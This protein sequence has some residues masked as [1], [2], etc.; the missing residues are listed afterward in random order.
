MN[1][2]VFRRSF[3]VSKAKRCAG[4]ANRVGADG[5]CRASRAHRRTERGMAAETPNTTRSKSRTPSVKQNVGSSRCSSNWIPYVGWSATY[6]AAYVM[7]TQK[8]FEFI[9][10]LGA[11]K[12]RADRLD[13]QH[14]HQ[15]D[16]LDALTTEC[17]VLRSRVGMSPALG[18]LICAMAMDGRMSA[19][20]IEALGTD[21]DGFV[22]LP[23]RCTACGNR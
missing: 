12:A 14:R 18:H 21:V 20:E 15:S 3:A 22:D 7:Q 9:Q 23:A 16:E 11:A 6:Q 1:G 10:Q 5:E 2:R 8:E 17:G 19:A 4:P 13:G